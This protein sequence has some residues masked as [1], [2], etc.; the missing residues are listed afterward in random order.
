M[1]FPVFSMFRLKIHALTYLKTKVFVS[2]DTWNFIL[3][4]YLLW[5]YIQFPL[6]PSIIFEYWLGTQ[7]LSESWGSKKREIICLLKPR[8][9]VEKFNSISQVLEI[10]FTNIIQ[11]NILKFKLPVYYL[12]RNQWSHFLDISS[13]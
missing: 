11:I 4:G 5:K 2:E 13:H 1:Y 9:F 7:K 12:K 6:V 3:N 8:I 10:G